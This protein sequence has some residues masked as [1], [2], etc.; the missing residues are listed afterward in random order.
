MEQA[1]SRMLRLMLHPAG[2][3]ERLYSCWEGCWT[4]P[5]KISFLGKVEHCNESNRQYMFSSDFI[6]SCFNE[7]ECDCGCECSILDCQ[8]P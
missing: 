3:R 1:D 6:P 5:D 8:W 4:H 7:Y 2:K